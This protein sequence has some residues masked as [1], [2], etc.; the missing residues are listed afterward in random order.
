[1]VNPFSYS[2]HVINALE[3]AL[4]QERLSTY[5]AAANGDHAAALRLYVWNT[6]IGAAFYGPQQ[7]LEILVRHEFWGD[8]ICLTGRVAEIRVAIAND[9]ICIAVLYDPHFHRVSLLLSADGSPPR[10]G[11]REHATDH[12]PPPSRRHIKSTGDPVPPPQPHLPDAFLRD[13]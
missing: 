12:H 8:E 2:P 13:A 5:L 7:T 11:T 4:S 9:P 6:E 10:D 1:M 3:R